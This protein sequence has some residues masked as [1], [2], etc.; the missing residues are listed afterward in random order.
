MNPERSTCRRT[1]SIC[2]PLT[3][4]DG[5]LCPLIDLRPVCISWIASETMESY[6]QRQWIGLNKPNQ[7][8]LLSDF[9]MCIHKVQLEQSRPT[10]DTVDWN[11]PL[12]P[13]WP[14]GNEKGK[15]KVSDWS[16]NLTHVYIIHLML[17]SRAMSGVVNSKWG[18]RRPTPT[19]SRR[20]GD[21]ETD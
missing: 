14:Q 18:A 13:G 17:A 16:R 10:V 19:A 4:I 12:A 11:L 20:R 8:S 2:Q 15:H 6:I 5:P 9:P 3:I 1:L 7:L 21:E